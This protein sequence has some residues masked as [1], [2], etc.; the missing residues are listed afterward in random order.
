MWYAPKQ[1][2]RKSGFRLFNYVALFHPAHRRAKS[3]WEQRDKEKLRCAP[4]AVCG[5]TCSNSAACVVNFHRITKVRFPPRNAVNV[6]NSTSEGG[7]LYKLLVGEC[8]ALNCC[9][10]ACYTRDGCLLPVEVKAHPPDKIFKN[11]NK[12]HPSEWKGQ[13]S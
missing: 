11:K 9:T 10:E 7:V 12:K 1:R 4:S 3:H 8:S 2:Q 6:S 5:R 13:I